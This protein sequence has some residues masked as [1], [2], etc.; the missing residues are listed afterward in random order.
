MQIDNIV[1]I[2]LECQR[3]KAKHVHPGG[4]LQPHEILEWKWDTISMDF[5]VGLPI[6]SRCHD[7][8][9]VMVDTLIKV[10]H[11]SPVQTSFTTTTVAQ[12]FL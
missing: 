3:V 4:L 1:V 6:S 11:F 2:C 7:A 8:I 10:A 12:V 5:I 9:M